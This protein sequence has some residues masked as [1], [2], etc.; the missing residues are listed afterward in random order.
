MTHTSQLF[1]GDYEMSF[2]IDRNKKEYE[3]WLMRLKT[4]QLVRISLD[5][6]LRYPSK[7]SK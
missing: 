5:S 1:V 2:D 4:L 7:I 3:D 6:W